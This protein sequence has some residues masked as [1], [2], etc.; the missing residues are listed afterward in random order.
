MSD[1]FGGLSFPVA[2]G[3]PIGDPTLKVLV[4][5]VAAVLNADAVDAWRTVTPSP[6]GL[7]VSLPVQQVE[8]HDPREAEFNPNRLPVLYGFRGQAQAN[9]DRAEDYNLDVGDITLHWV[10]PRAVQ[11][12]RALRAPFVN[13]IRKCIARAI[14]LER[15]PAYVAPGETDAKCRTVAALPTAIKTAIATATSPQ[16]YS[17]A[18][19]NGSVGTAAVSP[20]RPVTVTLDGDPSAFVAASTIAIAG[21]DVLNAATTWTLTI[22][23]LTSL[24]ITLTAPGD[25]RS[26]TGATVAAQASTSGTITVGL[27]AFTGLGSEA[28]DAAGV[29]S[30][31]MGAARMTELR[32]DTGDD[33]S[34][35]PLLEMTLNVTERLAIDTDSFPSRTLVGTTVAIQQSETFTDVMQLP[36][37]GG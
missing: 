11:E 29:F 34:T 26:V 7:P 16:S 35:Y 30:C 5:F 4:D 28:L 17:G 36:D 12:K 33:I 21:T 10:L 25:C 37:N 9:E 14:Y 3:D 18:A 13:A 31:T 23:T 24:P 15:H 2:S 19:L 20:Q 27:G 1:S 22:P 6:A 32:V 8:Y